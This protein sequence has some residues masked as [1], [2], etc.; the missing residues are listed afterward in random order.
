M[1]API[2][3]GGS[4]SQVLSGNASIFAR[5]SL[6]GAS[7]GRTLTA[8]ACQFKLEHTMRL[9]PQSLL[10]PL[11]AALLA[12]CSTIG[13]VNGV[14]VGRNATVSTMNEQS[15]CAQ[16]PAICIIGGAIGLGV[17]GYLVNQGNNGPDDHL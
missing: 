4:L 7:S 15:Y 12:G 1:G 6:S 5:S 2:F 13:T 17:L 10:F 11:I 14:P 3:A 16:N 9:T 8:A